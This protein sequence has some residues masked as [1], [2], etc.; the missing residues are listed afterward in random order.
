VG[1]GAVV[2]LTWATAL[3]GWM[4]QMAGGQVGVPLVRHVRADPPPGLF[5]GP[6]IGLAE[7]RRRT[8]GS[9]STWLTLSPCLFLAALAD[10]TIFKALITNEFGGGAIGWCCSG[11]RADTPSPDAAMRGGVLPAASSPSSACCSC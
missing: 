11:S 4:L 7:H 10:P 3:P 2:G 9:P 1:A 5:V 6:L 8:G